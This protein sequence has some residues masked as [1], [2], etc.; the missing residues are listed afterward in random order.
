MDHAEKISRSAA[1]ELAIDLVEQHGNMFMPNRNATASAEYYSEI[2]IANI[3]FKF[4]YQDGYEYIQC[5]HAL[6]LALLSHKTE[7]VLFVETITDSADEYY[8]F[9]SGSL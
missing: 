7:V 1:L 3:F 4:L 9:L 8:K 6:V 5:K 2:N